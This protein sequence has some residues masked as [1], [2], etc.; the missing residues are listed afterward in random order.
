VDSIDFR[1]R[2]AGSRRVVECCW[3]YLQPG[4]S[5]AAALTLL[6]FRE[7]RMADMKPQPERETRKPEPDLASVLCELEQLKAQR[8]K[9]TAEYR[10]D[11]SGRIA[12][13]TLRSYRE[14]KQE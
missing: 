12:S 9:G 4:P 3:S 13:V 5:L 11:G 7:V 6:F 2:R 1:E 8:W 14:I 10:L